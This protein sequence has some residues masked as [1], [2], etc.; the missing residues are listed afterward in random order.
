MC[1]T[2]TCFT[3]V[4]H[5][6]MCKIV[7]HCNFFF[8]K[9]RKYSKW[10]L[11]QLEHRRHLEE[12]SIRTGDVPSHYGS[13]SNINNG[14]EDDDDVSTSPKHCVDVTLEDIARNPPHYGDKRDRN[15]NDIMAYL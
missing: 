6:D 5:F 9:R 15:M 14:Y 12:Y 11:R 8:R 2:Y 4:S 13:L 7:Y 3:S 1:D 10:W